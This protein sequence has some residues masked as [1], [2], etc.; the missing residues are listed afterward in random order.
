MR[1]SVV[2]L[3]VLL[4]PVL[5]FANVAQ[6]FRYGRL[7]RRIEELESEQRALIEENKRAILAISVLTSPRRV[8]RLAEDELGLERITPESVVRLRTEREGGD[9]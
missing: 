7:E 4:V 3:L 1:R 6:A 9:P 8:G 2:A 5:L